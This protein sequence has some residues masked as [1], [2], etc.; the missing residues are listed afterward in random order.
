VAFCGSIDL[1]KGFDWMVSLIQN[2]AKN[3][4]HAA[5][6]RFLWIG[7][8][9]DQNLFDH[10]M[11]DLQQKGLSD[12]FVH[13]EQQTDVRPALTMA[14]IFFLCSRID[15]FSAPRT[16]QTRCQGPDSGPRPRKT[17]AKQGETR[18]SVI[19]VRGWSA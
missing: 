1:R 6:V 2:F 17:F 4:P 18:L 13:L 19:A 7:P 15:P 9:S 5:R 16:F 8:I 11:H 10:S 3:S 14:D 12:R